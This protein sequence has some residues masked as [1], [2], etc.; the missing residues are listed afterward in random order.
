MAKLRS[1]RRLYEQDFS[2]EDQPLVKSL[3][4]TVNSSFEELYGALNNKLTFRENLSC[5][6]AEF[7]V[8]VDSTGKPANKTQFKLEK[9]QLSVE[10]LIV[11]NAGG[12]ADPSL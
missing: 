6:F 1:Y 11:V 8:T 4:T 12:A 10:G 2:P 9:N 7:K 5:T 3:A